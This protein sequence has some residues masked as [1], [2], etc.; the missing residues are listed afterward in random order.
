MPSVRMASSYLTR[1]PRSCSKPSSA[2]NQ[3]GV[4]IAS[5]RCLPRVDDAHPSSFKRAG[6]AGGDG[7]AVGEGDGCNEGIGRFDRQAGSAAL[8]Q[9]L[10]IGFCA[11]HIERQHPICGQP[12][13]FCAR[14]RGH[15]GHH[16]ARQQRSAQGPVRRPGAQAR[17]PG[18]HGSSHCTTGGSHTVSF[19]KGA[20]RWA[21]M[22]LLGLDAP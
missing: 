9:Q 16:T 13:G 4:G 8:G 11:S 5:W 20:V 12:P 7:E 19:D 17:E 1:S 18:R 14:R 22:T 15:A 6:V 21:G 2:R 3:F 10:G